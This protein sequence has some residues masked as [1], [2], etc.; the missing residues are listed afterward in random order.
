MESGH[1]TI[2]KRGRLAPALRKIIAI[3]K[4]EW[5]KVLTY[6]L[7]IICFRLGNLIE[8]AFNVIIWTVIFQGAETIRGYTYSEMLTYLIVGYIITFIT[9]NYAFEHNISDFIHK[10]TLSNILLKPISFFEYVV[11]SALGR[12]SVTLFS[13]SL[14][15]VLL[16]VIFIPRM[17]A[18]ANAITLLIMMP[19][20]VMGYFIR[21]F[22]SI[23]IGMIA[24]WTIH[25]MGIQSSYRYIERFFAGGYFPINVLPTIFTTVSLALPFAYTWF[26]PLQLYLGKMSAMDGLKGLVIEIMWLFILYGIIK[27]VWK[28]G[29]KQYEGVGI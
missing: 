13:T 12:F 11:A 16:L 22:L 3:G 25:I 5:Q 1:Q 10:G 17:I 28:R 26:V 19:M 8:V 9:T 2:R 6:R 15:I 21:L 29:L 7:S 27:I 18:P 14:I 4:N 23:I 24:F 20:V